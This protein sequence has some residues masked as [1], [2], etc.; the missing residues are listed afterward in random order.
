MKD[1]SYLRTIRFS[2][3]E[4][5][6]VDRYLGQ[7]PVFDSFSSLARVA[8][9]DIIQRE[10]VLCLNPITKGARGKRPAFLWDYDLSESQVRELL[11]RPGLPP[12][13]AWLIERIL[14]ESRF[15]EVLEYLTLEEIRQAFPKL[16]LPPK[17]RERWAYALERWN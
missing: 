3:E 16:R 7:N 6:I 12:Q 10:G 15:E 4:G 5:E 11:N 9:L 1:R 8:I 13:K 17:T 14:T 2:K